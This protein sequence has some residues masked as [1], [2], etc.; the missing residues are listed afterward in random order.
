MDVVREEKDAIIKDMDF[1]KRKIEYMF[2]A[3]QALARREKEARV[4]ATAMN[5]SLA[6]GATLQ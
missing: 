5:D 4:V 6:Q 2:E 1:I 3:I